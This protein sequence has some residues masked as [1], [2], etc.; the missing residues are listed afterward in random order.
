MTDTINLD[1]ICARNGYKLTILVVAEIQKSN[2][3]EKKEKTAKIAENFITRILGVLQEHGIYAAFLLLASH[4]E[5][6]GKELGTTLITTLKEAGIHDLDRYETVLETLRQ[7]PGL[8][9]SLPTMLLAKQVLEQ[10]LIYAR[11][12][13][14]AE[15]AT[16]E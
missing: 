1:L 4:Q 3:K 12:H 13:A 10:T 5:T 15:G 7:E 8:L 11:Y 14:K 9:T 6:G 2:T 16:N